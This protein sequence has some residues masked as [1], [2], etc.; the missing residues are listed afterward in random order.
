VIDGWEWVLDWQH[1]SVYLLPLSDRKGE[2]RM[3]GYCY[4]IYFSYVLHSCYK[5]SYKNAGRKGGSQ[6]RLFDVHHVLTVVLVSASFR[7]GMWRGGALTRLIHD[8]A[9]IIL[10][11]AMIMKVMHE[12][13][14][15]P[16]WCI[17]FL[18][19]LNLISWFAT[20]IGIYGWLCWNMLNAYL[21][22]DTRR[23]STGVWVAGITSL[24]GSIVMWVVQIAFYIGL[25]RSFIQFTRSGKVADPFHGSGAEVKKQ[26]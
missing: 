5:D 23:Y 25:V 7:Y 17:T 13:N 26:A 19:C 8:C 11:I 21:A 9:D 6:Q 12:N 20:R 22:T 10:Y 18:Y 14:K 2:Q 15:I 24:I 3:V 1:W 16:D 4:C